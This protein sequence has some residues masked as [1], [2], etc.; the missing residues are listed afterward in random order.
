MNSEKKRITEI[1]KQNK[2]SSCDACR[3]ICPT[4]A[5]NIKKINGQF[6]PFIEEEKCINCGLCYYVCPNK[7][8]EN[9]DSLNLSFSIKSKN[10]EFFK[11]STSGGIVTTLVYNLLKDNLYDSAFLLKFDDINQQPAFLEEVS[12]RDYKK[13]IEFS[14]SKYIPASIFYVIKKI[15]K[16]PNKKYIIV[17]TPC[18]ITAIKNFVDLKKMN[19][20][21]IL[22]IGLFCAQTQNYNF[23]EFLGNFFNIKKKKI[24]KINFREKNKNKDITKIFYEDGSIKNLKGF[25]RIIYKKYFT[26]KSCEY[27]EKKLNYNSDISCGDNYINRNSELKSN[28]IINTKKGFDIFNEYK[29]HFIFKKE[30]IKNIEK[31]QKISSK[32]GLPKNTKK[33][34]LLIKLLGLLTLPLDL[35]KNKKYSSHKKRRNFIIFGGGTFGKGAETMTYCLVDFIRKKYPKNEIYLFS[36]RD[37]K[38]D[39]KIKKNFRFK[40]IKWD[41]KNKFINLFLPKFLMKNKIK[42][43]FENCDCAIDISGF[44]LSSQFNFLNSFNFL[45]N[46][47]MTKKYQKKYICLPQSFGPFD[48]GIKTKLIKYFI[49]KHMNYP[50][51]IYTRENISFKNMKNVLKRDYK[52]SCDIVLQYDYDYKNIVLNN[53]IKE[54]GI[55]KNSVCIIPNRMLLDYI[56]KEDLL[57][58]YRIII[59]YLLKMKKNIYL[60]GYSHDDQNFINDL[61]KLNKN[62]IHI[63]NK[64]NCYETELLIKKFDFLI[65][66][67]YHSI[68]H[69]YKNSVPVIIFG[70]SHKYK[71]I[72]ELFEQKKY[73]FDIRKKI[74]VDEL[75][76]KLKIISGN[77][78]KESIEIN[79]KRKEIINK[80]IFNDLEL[81]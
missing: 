47:K 1:V 38:L 5:I 68:I 7:N 60:F 78:K 65:A 59:N 14:K 63:N 39:D 13:V 23:I 51:I 40:I 10:K 29:N 21:N 69:S 57:E 48:F 61:L 28:I 44:A 12:K 72:S 66:S 9:Q 3:A 81:L 70:W 25:F 50:S 32:R 27:C 33:N 62:I 64:L 31:S 77:R 36:R 4:N 49:K 80:S 30:G 41:I 2:C 75:I 74:N 15:K 79:K 22:L 26:L 67:R 8:N 73:F 76:K 55:K 58:I 35:L 16:T 43:I 20:N 11:K 45:G 24:K 17:G 19:K 18:Q 52:K 34:F 37:Y 46:I 6:L 53:K 56:K 42:E 54:I 71:E